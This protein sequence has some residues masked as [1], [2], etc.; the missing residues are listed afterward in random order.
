MAR[1]TDTGSHPFP[2]VRPLSGW[3]LSPRGRAP[4]SRTAAAR[5]GTLAG[6]CVLL[7]GSAPSPAQNPEGSVRA[8]VRE[9]P[10]QRL[11]PRVVE[12]WVWELCAEMREEP[13]CRVVGVVGGEQPRV[14]V[15]GTDRVHA[16]IARKLAESEAVS[17]PARTFQLVLLEASRKGTGGGEVDPA[18]SEAARAALRDV[19]DY[20]PFSSFRVLDTA[21]LSTTWRAQTSLSGPDGLQYSAEL[22]FRDQ[23]GLEGPRIEVQELEVRGEVVVELDPPPIPQGGTETA[24]PPRRTKNVQKLLSTSLSM[25]PGETAVVGTSRLD[26]GEQALVVLLTAIEP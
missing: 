23:Q 17:R 15:E 5:A 2:G 25:R 18:L 4:R 20:L 6:L 12:T 26:G 24:E 22:A 19:A 16:R 7:A 21:L 14:G 10:L 11:D 13:T 1:F 9:F 8:Y 3:P